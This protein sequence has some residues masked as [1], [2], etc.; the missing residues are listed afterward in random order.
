MPLH[1]F[2]LI[3][4]YIY[5]LMRTVLVLL[6][7]HVFRCN[8]TSDFVD[9]ELLIDVDGHLSEDRVVRHSHERA[10]GAPLV[11]VVNDLGFLRA[12]SAIRSALCLKQTQDACESEM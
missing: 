12:L 5:F 10:V 2:F 8:H 4:I 6:C 9:A 11:I 1:V 3:Y 7:S